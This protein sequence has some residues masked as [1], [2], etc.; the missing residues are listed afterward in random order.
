MIYAAN[1]IPEIADNLVEIDNTIAGALPRK[2]VSLRSG[3][4]SGKKS[5][6]R[7]KADGREVPAKVERCWRRE[8]PTSI[9]R[10]MASEAFGLCLKE[11]QTRSVSSGVILRNPSRIGRKV[12]KKNAGASLVDL[13]D[14]V[15]AWSSIRR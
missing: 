11:L 13:G 12:I 15:A 3:T 7:M 4:L 14:G 5:V 6:A 2:W 8:I 1:R 10:S 9:N